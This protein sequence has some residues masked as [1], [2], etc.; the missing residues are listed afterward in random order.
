MVRRSC[1]LWVQDKEDWKSGE[2]QPKPVPRGY[3][4][5][6][7]PHL[8][9]QEGSAAV[10]ECSGREMKMERKNSERV[11]KRSIKLKC[12]KDAEVGVYL[13]YFILA[14]MHP[15]ESLDSCTSGPYRLRL[16]LESGTQ[17]RRLGVGPFLIPFSGSHTIP[18]VGCVELHCAAHLLMI[19]SIPNEMLSLQ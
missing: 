7:E 15:G 2:P 6:R 10:R 11:V 19:L 9:L 14:C 3:L 1:S 12:L 5:G 8:F 4:M 16:L 18:C 13:P 17:A